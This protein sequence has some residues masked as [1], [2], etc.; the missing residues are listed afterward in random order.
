MYK[1]YFSESKISSGSKRDQAHDGQNE[2]GYSRRRFLAE[3]A[4]ALAGAALFPS[5]GLAQG[6]R[7]PVV[8]AQSV[9]GAGSS[10]HIAFPTAA[11]ENLDRVVS[12]S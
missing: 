4:A 1:I 10:P 7:G 8:P 9:V 11:R 5:L 3:S 2:L 12:L 6:S